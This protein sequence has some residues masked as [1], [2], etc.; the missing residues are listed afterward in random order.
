MQQRIMTSKL[1]KHRPSL[2][3]SCSTIVGG[4]CVIAIIISHISDEI[5]GKLQFNCSYYYYNISAKHQQNVNRAGTYTQTSETLGATS[6]VLLSTSRCSQATLE[7][8]KVI[9]DSAKAFSG[10]P[11]STCSDGGTFRML[12]YLTIRRVKFWNRRD[13]CSALQ[14]TWYRILIGV[15][16]RYLQALSS[17]HIRLCYSQTF[18]YIIVWHALFK[19]M[20]IHTVNLAADG[21]WA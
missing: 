13:R 1:L 4:L 7:L 17:Y 18:C 14:G 11:E 12:R 9:S 2:R 21:S 3:W 15:V 8:S 10:V 5:W 6:P 16:V 19:S 20:Y